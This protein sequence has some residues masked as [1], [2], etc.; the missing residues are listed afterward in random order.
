MQLRLAAGTRAQIADTTS[1]RV[2]SV[3]SITCTP[4]A[5]EVNWATVESSRSRRI[6]WSV[7]ACD[8]GLVGQL[9][10]PAG[11]PGLRV[12]DQQHPYVGVRRDHG[13]DVSALGD[14][15]PPASAISSFCRATRSA[16]T[17]RLVATALTTADTS[18][19]ADG[20]RSRR[21][22]RSRW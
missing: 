21:C 2:S 1:S 8:V 11:D 16:R 12:G 22:R 7:T 4:G 19:C 20:R 14:D 10:V 15:P 13:G 3:E 5:A 18:G 9:G 6:T 17:S